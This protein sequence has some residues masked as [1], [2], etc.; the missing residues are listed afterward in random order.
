MTDLMPASKNDQ[1][2]M[3]SLEI[4]QITRKEHKNVVRDIRALLDALKKD[5]SVLSH[6]CTEEK[7][8]RGYTACFHLDRELTETLVTGYSV[9]LRHKVIKRLHE[10]ER[11]QSTPDWLEN[12]SPHARVVIEDLN[13]QVNH[14]REETDR[15]N[16]VCN[17][18]AQNLKDGITPVEFC[19]MLNGVHLNRVQP[20]LVDRKRLLRTEHGYRS[21]AAYRDR[22]FTERRYLN[23][24]GR[25]CEKVVLTQKGAKWLYAEY[26]KGRLTMRKDWDGN[27]SHLVFETGVAA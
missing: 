27:F 12:L 13:S 6:Q 3:S 23:R 18:L 4:A 11:Q 15:L 17:D 26:E 8:A 24:D 19:R 16:S 7:D 5:G 2:T 9:P 14:Y 1:L 25:T 20:D 10:L 22:L 21:A